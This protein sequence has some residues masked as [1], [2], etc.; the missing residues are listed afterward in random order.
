MS[1]APLNALR[2]FEAVARHGSFSRAAEELFVTQSAIS[3]QVRNLEAWLGAPLL[4]R[5]GNRP[6]LRPHAADLGYTLTLALADI[7]SAC[8]QAMRADARPTLTVAVIPSVAICWLIPRLAGFRHLWPGIDTRIQYAIHGRDI[9][10]GSVDIAVVYSEGPPALPGTTATHFLPGESIPVCAATVARGNA[11]IGTPAGMVA[12]GLLH[13]TDPSGWR[14]WLAASGADPAEAESG[15]V[16][17]DFNLL[18]AAALAGQG[19]AIC[20]LAIIRDDLEAGRL[21]ALS[22]TAI[23]R[24]FAYYVVR[25]QTAGSR[26]SPARAAFCDWLLSTAAPN[27]PPDRPEAAGQ[28]CDDGP[29]VA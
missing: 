10:F 14:T 16:F 19:V 9:D 4:D 25:R 8:R 23:R 6:R 7:D 28:A 15:P 2:A 5:D 1:H 13:D 11:A 27:W 22:K 17:E 18:R 21:V 3:H 24:E 12:A 29:E 20:P 26:A